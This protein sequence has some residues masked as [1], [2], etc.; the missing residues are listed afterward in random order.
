MRAARVCFK[1]PYSDR[2]GGYGLS[3]ILRDGSDALELSDERMQV[4]V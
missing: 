2:Q 1:V 3:F 4:G